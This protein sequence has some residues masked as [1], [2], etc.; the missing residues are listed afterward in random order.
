MTLQI[1][2]SLINSMLMIHVD[3]DKPYAWQPS[4]IDVQMLKL[5]QLIIVAV[6]GEFT[7]MAGRRLKGA[8]KLEARKHG[9]HNAKVKVWFRFFVKTFKYYIAGGVGWAFQRLHPLCDH[10]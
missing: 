6:P 4:I 8:I 7:T 9:V 5:G 3:M 10:P 2:A 1:G